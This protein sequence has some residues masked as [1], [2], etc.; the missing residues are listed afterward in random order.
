MP[1]EYN[2]GAENSLSENKTNK[3]QQD[4]V[5]SRPDKMPSCG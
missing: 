3:K 4:R 5:K 1:I 2:G